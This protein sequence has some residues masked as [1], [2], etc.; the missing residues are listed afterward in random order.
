[1]K[2]KKSIA[3]IIIA[4]LLVLSMCGSFLS[5]APV[6]AQKEQET[7]EQEKST[8]ENTENASEDTKEESAKENKVEK[9]SNEN[10]KKD[11]IAP[12]E[13]DSENSVENETQ[14]E[15]EPFTMKVTFDGS[16]LAA[17]SENNIID[18]WSGNTSKMM[19]V[20]I[21]RNK[22]VKVDS[23]KQYVLCMKTSN[24]FYFNGVPEAEKI[25]GAEEVAMVKNPTPTVNKSG[26][27]EGSLDGFSNYS[28]EIRIKLNSA[29]EKIT[30]P[31]VGI[32][33][34]LRLL[35]FN[36]TS[37]QKVSNPFQVEI[38]SV[39]SGTSLSQ[40]SENDKENLQ[41]VKVQ[42]IMMKTGSLSSTNWKSAMST[43]YFNN[44]ILMQP[45]TLGKDGHISYY[46][47]TAGVERQVY[48]SMTIVVNCPYIEVNGE[49]HYLEVATDDIALKE[50]KKQDEEKIRATGYKMKDSAVYN[51]EEHTITYTFENI[52]LGGHTPLLY[53]PEFSWPS[54][55]TKEL[56]DEQSYTIQG[57][58]FKVTEQTGYLGFTS[59]LK[60]NFTQPD[61]YSATFLPKQVNVK[62]A[63]SKESGNDVAKRYIYHDLTRKNGN[64]G[65][66]GFFDIHNDGTE[67]SSL[68]NVEYEFNTGSDD[69][70]IYYV[71]RVNLAVYGNKNGTDVSYVLSD[72]E[73]DITGIKH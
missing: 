6:E 33:Y 45:V 38:D 36:G 47:G 69:K 43:D 24:V 27:Q 2:H 26:G 61:N 49:K 13:G 21:S 51:A 63:S 1:M 46:F 50:N 25:T 64:E 3:R 67:D 35:G 10:S 60:S 68:L 66:L 44:A 5:I 65:T 30:I 58:S 22:N 57:V 62:M 11:V 16:D 9:G 42:S 52:Y 48:K 23:D 15:E 40:I 41:Q 53:T 54:D 73:N 31:D 8:E 28:G 19:T 39:D 55:L 72:G 17:N 12:L 70:A 4:L 71:T 7:M 29:V 32:S 34:N 56:E 59:T 20:V 18:V 37:A 14:N